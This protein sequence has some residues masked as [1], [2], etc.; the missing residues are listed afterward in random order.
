MRGRDIKRYSYEF[1]NIYLINTHNGY[2]DSHGN[3]VDRIDVN[4]YPAIKRHLDKYWDKIEK[5]YDQGET[6][7]NLRNCAYMEDFNRQ[8][9]AWNRIASEKQYSLI[10]EGIY[11][12]DSMHFITGKKLEYLCAILNSSLFSWLMNLI[13]GKAAGGNAGN[14]DNIR[15][16]YVFKPEMN[17]EIE[18]IDLLN[19]KQFK[20]IDK[21]IFKVY[22]LNEYEI[23]I[24]ENL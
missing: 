2:I 11:I 13:V 18:I 4:N 1:A 21:V 20:H 16:L 6:P 12:Q 24:I 17:L 5:R 9:I 8:K 23:S 15:D 7:Y 3:Q 10:D 22:Q 19:S 14:S